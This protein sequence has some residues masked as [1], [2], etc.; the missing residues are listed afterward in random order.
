MDQPGGSEELSRKGIGAGALDRGLL[1]IG[2][3]SDEIEGMARA[4][5]LW[6]MQFRL[7]SSQQLIPTVI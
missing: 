3:Y 1:A 2:N 7:Y 6:S 4:N 5:H